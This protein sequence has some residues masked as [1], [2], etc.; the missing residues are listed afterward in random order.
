M[1]TTA[2]FGTT[3]AVDIVP[4]PKDCPIGLPARFNRPSGT[5]GCFSHTFRSPLPAGEAV[6]HG[7]RPS[8]A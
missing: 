8:S 4:K 5:C 3:V 2:S 1:R 7:H 6:P